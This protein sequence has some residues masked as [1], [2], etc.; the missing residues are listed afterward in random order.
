MDK[1]VLTKKQF[2]RWFNSTSSRSWQ[3]LVAESQKLE[4]IERW[5]VY[6]ADGEYLITYESKEIAICNYPTAKHRI[7][8]L[9]E[10]V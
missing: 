8:L 10:V 5:A 3:S 4:L 2:D 9:R 1:I 7:V 6:D